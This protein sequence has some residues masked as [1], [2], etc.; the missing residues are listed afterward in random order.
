MLVLIGNLRNYGERHYRMGNVMLIEVF[1]VMGLAVCTMVILYYALL[2]LFKKNMLRSIA[3]LLALIIGM[4]CQ[5][6]FGRCCLIPDY[7]TKN[8]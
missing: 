5:T 8:E 7:G 1:V 2:D 4:I 3:H 6:I